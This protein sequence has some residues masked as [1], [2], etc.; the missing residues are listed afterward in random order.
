MHGE[1]RKVKVLKWLRLKIE[2]LKKGAQ[3]AHLWSLIA[4]LAE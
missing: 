2:T 1:I 4:T 3:S